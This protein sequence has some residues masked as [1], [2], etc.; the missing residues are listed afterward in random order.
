MSCCRSTES[1]DVEDY[2]QIDKVTR[3]LADTDRFQKDLD[4]P[5]KGPK[6]QALFSALQRLHVQVRTP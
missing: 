5:V 2:R 1:P 4:H 3:L 6:L